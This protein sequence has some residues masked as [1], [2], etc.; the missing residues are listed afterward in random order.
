MEQYKKDFI[1]WCE[2][3]VGSNSDGS[4]GKEQ[5]IAYRL[6]VEEMCR[7]AVYFRSTVEKELK[8]LE[9]NYDNNSRH[10]SFRLDGVPHSNR[11]FYIQALNDIRS[12][13]G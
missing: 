13:L 4:G 8:R 9:Q 2:N 12:F 5:K 1:E 11:D 3:Q 7:I 10:A 6:S